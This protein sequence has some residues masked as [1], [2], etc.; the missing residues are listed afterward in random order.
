MSVTI[1]QSGSLVT[2]VSLVG[3][4]A[5]GT[6]YGLIIR[7]TDSDQDSAILLFDDETARDSYVTSGSF[8]IPPEMVASY[9][10]SNS[11]LGGGTYNLVQRNA[12]GI[13]GTVTVTGFTNGYTFELVTD[14][15]SGTPAEPTLYFNQ[16]FDFHNL[17]PYNRCGTNIC[18]N[19]V[20]PSGSGGS[21]YEV[22]PQIYN[23]FSS[24]LNRNHY[25]ENNFVSYSDARIR[26]LS[27]FDLS[28][29]FTLGVH[30]FT[31]GSDTTVFE[32]G[33]VFRLTNSRFYSKSSGSNI[34]R[35]IPNSGTEVDVVIRRLSGTYRVYG[36]LSGLDYVEFTPPS[37]D[38]PVNNNTFLLPFVSGNLCEV[39]Y[40]PSGWSDNDLN[41]Y[42]RAK[43]TLQT[44]LIEPSGYVVAEVPQ[45][46]GYNEIELSV[47][48][49]FNI[50]N[51]SP[52]FY[53]LN[54]PTVIDYQSVVNNS[55]YY[56]DIETS[57]NF[58]FTYSGQINYG[59]GN[60]SF[61]GNINSGNNINTIIPVYRS[62]NNLL[63]SS[64]NTNFTYNSKLLL[65]GSYS[66]YIKVHNLDV[67]LNAYES[68]LTSNNNLNFY[69]NTIEYI[70]RNLNF[71]TVG[72]TSLN[73]GVDMIVS[74]IN[75]EDRGIDLFLKRN[76]RVDNAVNFYLNNVFASVDI[77]D[78]I[79]S[80]TDKKEESSF[81]LYTFGS[82]LSNSG[83]DMLVSGVGLEDASINL[84]TYNSPYGF[85]ISNSGNESP[86]TSGY[87][88]KSVNF[89]VPSIN[90]N[91]SINFYINSS[92]FSGTS[93]NF[94]TVSEYKHEDKY[95]DFAMVNLRSGI[96]DNINFALQS[97]E[98]K[99]T[100]FDMFIAR[101]SE[102]IDKSLEMFVKTNSGISNELNFFVSGANIEYNTID[103]V[104][105]GTGTKDN[106]VR[107]MTHGF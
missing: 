14:D 40:S 4:P 70:D 36:L 43:Y 7:E 21:S 25:G 71:A 54:Q 98:F 24:N 23:Y 22:S 45:S 42:F 6:T 76:L 17:S 107:L 82:F 46:S 11:F 18:I 35:V 95:I 1:V 3:L 26:V 60:T 2:S 31:S 72:H 80:G 47:L 53:E 56:V 77:I 64:D 10:S 75:L 104:T 8:Y 88:N 13:S 62:T 48:P 12:S 58:P 34:S 94:C 83:L 59:N 96:D 63:T 66:G 100:S 50:K 97:S 16:Y 91:N 28:S 15:G 38:T 33:G 74:G 9:T 101:D 61:I 30:A 65:N 89:H 44:H 90:Y 20:F 78:F 57:S 85:N 39:L 69:L 27:G 49:N 67:V 32:N 99:T 81:E 106:M 29:D 93:I 5:V 19:H 37:I 102:A 52:F 79:T 92:A 87:I 103:M 105:S 55:G 86:A 73:S 51:K 68:I 84:S 41:T